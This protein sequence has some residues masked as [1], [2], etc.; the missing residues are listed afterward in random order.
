MVTLP[1]GSEVDEVVEEGAGGYSLVNYTSM[2]IHY[3]W[4]DYRMGL[5][6]NGNN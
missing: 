2:L 6:P 1:G 3:S 4:S 5:K